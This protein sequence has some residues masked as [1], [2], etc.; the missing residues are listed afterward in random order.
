MPLV[1]II[2]PTFNRENTIVDTLD[3]VLS[4]AY[5]N[6]ECIVVDDG[7]K[8]NTVSLL[9][10]YCKKDSRFRYYQRPSQKKKG[11][12]S[13]RN[14]GFEKSNGSF[15]QWLD[16]DDL[17]SKSCFKKRVQTILEKQL[18]FVVASTAYL[19]NNSNKTIVNRDLGHVAN[20][21]YLLQFLSYKL[22]WCIL[23]PMWKRS[24]I[25]EFPFDENLQRF[26]D[27]DL[28]IRILASNKFKFA[29]L[30]EVD[31]YYR[32]ESNNVKDAAHIKKVLNSFVLLFNKSQILMNT[33]TRKKHFRVF[34]STILYSYYFPN[35][36]LFK[37]E[38]NDII[39]I[40]SRS[41]V[42]N[43]YQKKL[44]SFE[45]LI[46]E[47]KANKIKYIGVYRLRNWIKSQLLSL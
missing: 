27:V 9:D 20:E 30:Y 25:K 22:P 10:R 8:D 34:V 3:S 38:V 33:I 45:S 14:Y 24:I 47:K 2:I 40:I 13:C 12:N 28:H 39:K 17:L 32:I 37:K 42:Y 4:Q 1:S 5:S 11:A 7:S 26:Q 35:Y 43:F 21:N 18:D 23:S 19:N 16:S 41:N 46:L 31:T 6:W 44:L 36:V 29:R 15:I